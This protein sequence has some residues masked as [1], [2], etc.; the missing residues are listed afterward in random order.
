MIKTII[1]SGQI[2]VKS[3]Y[4]KD[5]IKGSKMIQGKW[6]STYWCFP[7]E[8]ITELRELLL[9]VYGECGELS[10][11]VEAAV[12]VEL[13]LDEYTDISDCVRIGSMTVASRPG[14]DRMVHLS[15]NTMCIKG[16]FPES[17]GSVKNP[18]VYPKD[19][20]VLRAKNVPVKLYER[21]K[22][23][24]GVSL[25]NVD[26]AKLIEERERLLARLAEIESLL[27]E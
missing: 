23:M 7:E 10:E 20:T 9:D 18:R 2:K 12:T 14:R 16:G 26:R 4:N 25:V 11:G 24:A 17:G 5:F 13:D 8:N 6:N 21:I 27:A 15:D 19:G 3:E 22:D 1:E